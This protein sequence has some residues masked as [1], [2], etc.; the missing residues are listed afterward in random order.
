M[1]IF[2][3]GDGQNLQAVHLRHVE[4]DDQKIV[5]LGFEHRKRAGTRGGGSH[6]GHATQMFAQHLLV[7]FQEGGIVIREQDFGSTSHNPLS[8]SLI[9]A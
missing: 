5:R 4:I 2:A 9:V 6:F 3:A 7:Q 1:R 8:A